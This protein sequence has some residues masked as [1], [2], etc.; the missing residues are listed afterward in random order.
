MM[1]DDMTS[2][3]HL[4]R[5]RLPLHRALL[6]FVADAM[7]DVTTEERDHTSAATQHTS[8]RATSRG[9]YVR[10]RRGGGDRDGH[11]AQCTT[12]TDRNLREEA[13]N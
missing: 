6:T 5:M 12:R 1:M 3:A 11:V 4:L 10:G 8:R 13:Q 7:H 9:S 2:R